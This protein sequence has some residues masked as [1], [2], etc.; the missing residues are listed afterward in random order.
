MF[1]FLAIFAIVLSFG[2]IPFLIASVFHKTSRDD[3]EFEKEF[4]D[5]KQPTESDGR[6]AGD[7]NATWGGD[8]VAPDL[9]E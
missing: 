7:G 5:T 3:L 2:A 1:S 9:W 4:F 8:G 6:W